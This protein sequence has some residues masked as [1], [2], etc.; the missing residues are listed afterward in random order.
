MP[1]DETE[2]IQTNPAFADVF[3]PIHS[4]TAGGFR[5]VK[6]NGDETIPTDYPIEF[7]QRLLHRCFAGNVVTRSENMRGVEANT[8]AL[9]LA[10]VV[11]DICKLLKFVSET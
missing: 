2:R 6:V 9:G 3:M 7:A 10:H 11:D 4:R 8:E 1:H 5:I